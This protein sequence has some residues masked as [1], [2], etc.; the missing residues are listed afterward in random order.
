MSTFWRISISLTVNHMCFEMKIVYNDIK[1][2]S[3]ILACTYDVSV[4]RI[5]IVNKHLK[6]KQ[7]LVWW[8]GWGESCIWCFSLPQQR[9]RETNVCITKTFTNQPVIFYLTQQPPQWTRASS[10][11]RFLHH[12]TRRTT[13]GRTPLDEWSARRRD[14]YLTTPNTHHGQTSTPPTGFEPT[15]SAGER[16]QTYV[17]DR[18]ATATGNQ[19]LYTF[20]H[21]YR[22]S[23]HYQSF[24]FINW[25][26]SELS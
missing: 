7:R 3:K 4:M 8:K 2:D 12:T 23:S 9:L 5:R 24:S 17:L 11:T 10:F 1:D 16:P 13:V 15:I 25:S 6:R 22:A 14:L 21:T 18:V 20:S 26:T 19:P